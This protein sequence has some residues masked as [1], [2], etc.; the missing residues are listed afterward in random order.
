MH[1][2]AFRVVSFYA[3][4]ACAFGGLSR[5]RGSAGA[6]AAARSVPERCSQE[7][8]EESGLE[9]DS[10][11]EV[12][13]ELEEDES[14]EEVAFGV[15]SGFR[16]ESYS[17]KTPA[18]NQVHARSMY[19][20]LVPLVCL[21]REASVGSGAVRFSFFVASTTSFPHARKTAARVLWKCHFL[22]SGLRGAF[23][24][25]RRRHE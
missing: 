15:S 5:R 14:V 3:G 18:S 12:K 11:E 10:E 2:I 4:V 6:A 1:H 8:Q 23:R 17:S 21:S 22:N 19:S 13:P 20:A 16:T 9:E 7:D 24:V 25:E